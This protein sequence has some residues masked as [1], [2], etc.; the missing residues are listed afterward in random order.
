MDTQLSEEKFFF[1]FFLIKHI[2]MP[3][4]SDPVLSSYVAAKE[5]HR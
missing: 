3:P 4:V 5:G 1:N 2:G